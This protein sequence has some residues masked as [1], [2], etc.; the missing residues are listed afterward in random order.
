MRRSIKH[1]ACIYLY[2]SHY[3][4]RIPP[5]AEFSGPQA[6]GLIAN[7]AAGLIPNNQLSCCRL[8]TATLESR[9]LVVTKNRKDMKVRNAVAAWLHIALIDK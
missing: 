2:N 6:A 9:F 5:H 4:K 8:Q 3:D 7:N 1:I